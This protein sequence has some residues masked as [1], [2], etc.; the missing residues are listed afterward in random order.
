MRR[1]VVLTVGLL[2][3]GAVP[4]QAGESDVTVRCGGGARVRLE[5]DDLGDRVRL[6]FVVHGS[7]PGD[8]WTVWIHR[9]TPM[10]GGS[11]V[12]HGTMVASDGG[13][14]VVRQFYR[15][16][17]KIYGVRARDW[18]TDQECEAFADLYPASTA[19][20]VVERAECNFF[21]PEARAHLKLRDMGD[22][23]KVWFVLHQMTTPGHRWRIALRH[24]RA[25]DPFE[26]GDGRVFFVG[27]RVATGES[28]D[29]AVQQSVVE[30]I[31]E[32]WFAGDGF[33]AKARDRQTGQFCHVHTGI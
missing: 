32:D 18:Q 29:L 19:P 14:F 21:Q 26:H 17:G 33:A 24:G 25:L 1:I 7:A 20:D 9:H 31:E 10:G 8:R 22:R 3:L 15:D 4:A 16:N 30:R 2:V 28:G 23:I 5:L 27:T 13:D 6:R 12:F 11:L